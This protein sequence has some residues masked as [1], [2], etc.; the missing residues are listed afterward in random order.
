MQILTTGSAQRPMRSHGRQEK[1]TQ[2]E[3]RNVALSH[4]D[5]PRMKTTNLLIFCLALLCL[6]LAFTTAH[7]Q[8]TA[9]PSS[10][11]GLVAEE[12]G[13]QVV[14][15]D[16]L[17]RCGTFWWIISSGK[18]G[19]TALPMPIPVPSQTTYEVADG[20]FI[21]DGVA[22]EVASEQTLEAQATSVQNL[23]NQIQG[24]QAALQMRTAMGTGLGGMP[25][26]DGGN[27]NGWDGGGTGIPINYPRLVINSNLLWLQI[28]NVSDGTVYANLYNATDQI[29][30]PSVFAIWSTT[31]LALPRNL[32]QVETEL[33]YPDT[34]CQPFTVSTLGRQN[35]FLLA[36]D[37]TGVEINGLQAW[38]MWEFCGNLNQ[39]AATLDV[40]GRTL[41][42][43]Y[44][45]GL[46]PNIVSGPDS[47]VLQFTNGLRISIFEPKPA[48]SIP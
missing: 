41:L 5:N 9:L 18:N 35:L 26:F 47:N 43:D 39:T 12:N 19:Y 25:G 8:S 10:V 46:N 42:Y 1:T 20:I 21:M 13:L 45:N 28:T 40:N 29:A 37:W 4:A 23:I 7:A 14:P 15:A 22:G 2:I 33:Q 31:N 17:P 6:A 27:T 36:E 30:V 24:T 11:L 16:Q 48:S 3:A 44:Q 34:N 38:W 32:W